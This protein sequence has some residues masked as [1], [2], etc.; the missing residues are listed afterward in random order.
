MCNNNFYNLFVPMHKKLKYFTQQIMASNILHFNTLKHFMHH[1]MSTVLCLTCS[2]MP[3][4]I[5]MQYF[6][7][8]S[9]TV[10]MFH[11]FHFLMYHDVFCSFLSAILRVLYVTLSSS[12]I[13][14][15]ACAQC[16]GCFKEINSINSLLTYVC[17]YNAW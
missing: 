2:D 3:L 12:S 11:V 6:Y 4:H 7:D 14:S 5:S 13:K 16:Y 1:I 10:F 17:Y 9:K 8:A 15:T